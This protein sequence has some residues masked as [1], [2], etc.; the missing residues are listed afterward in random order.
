MNGTRAQE[1]W[2]EMKIGQPQSTF[3]EFAEKH[4]VQFSFSPEQQSLFDED[5]PVVLT[6]SQLDQLTEQISRQVGLEAYLE[7][8]AQHIAP[9]CMSLYVMNDDTWAL[10]E[11]KPWDKDKMLAMTTMPYC[12]WD[13][14]EEHG[15][16]LKGVKKWDL[17]STIIAFRGNPPNL[18]I[19]GN[20]GDF[21]G[22]ANRGMTT[23]RRFGLPEMDNKLVPRYTFQKIQIH[24]ELNEAKVFLHPKPCKEFDYDFSEPAKLFHD[25]GVH[26]ELPGDDVT[27][28]V[29]KRKPSRLRGRVHLLVAGSNKPDIDS[30]KALM[31][32]IWLWT[33][34]RLM[35]Q[36]GEY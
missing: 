26:L 8:N 13:A 23:L 25:Y 30:F 11:R 2:I 20:G 31:T 33:F 28:T 5:Q 36:R 12:F 19:E 29:E 1:S 24:A 32:D 14:N 34:N 15:S 27:L 18:T 16:N 22:F 4:N 3:E 9:I 10:M 6:T 35:A 17:G 21:S 7:A